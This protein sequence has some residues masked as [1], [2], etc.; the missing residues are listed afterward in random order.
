MIWVLSCTTFVA[1]R[2]GDP[3]APGVAQPI[4]VQVFLT[5]AATSAVLATR[6]VHAV[7]A[8]IAVA[9][10]VGGVLA[11]VIH[12]GPWLLARLDDVEPD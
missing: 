10:G 1:C 5:A 7:V 3:D 9:A 4:A 8:G 6:D 11:A 2:F 12:G